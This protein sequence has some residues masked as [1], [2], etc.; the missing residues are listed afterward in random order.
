MRKFFFI[1]LALPFIIKADVVW[2][3]IDG[4][5]HPVSSNYIKNG[6]A[7]AEKIKADLIVIEMNTPGG[8][9]TSMREIITSILNTV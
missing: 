7:F 1:I 5:I 6:I 9:M 8:L 3:K 2:L 4:I